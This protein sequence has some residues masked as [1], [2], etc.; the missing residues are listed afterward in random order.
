MSSRNRRATVVSPQEAPKTGR[1]TARIVEPIAG[2]ALYQERARLAFPLLVRQAEA[3]Q[4]II[5]SD[6]S[7]ELGMPNPRNLNYVLGSIG[8]TIEN[9]SKI[10]KETIPPIQS[11][12][13]NK[14]TGLPGEGVSWFLRDWGDF[15]NLPRR[16]QKELVA[17]AHAMVFAY[18][19]WHA[20][21]RKF[22]LEPVN[23][24]FSSFVQE[25]SGPRTGF[26]GGEGERHRALKR[27]VARNPACIGLAKSTPP[28]RNERPL[29]SGDCVDVSFESTEQWI[30]AEVKTTLSDVADITR[31]L[32]QCVKYRAVMEAVQAAEGRPRAAR[33]ILVLEGKLPPALISLRNVL[34]VEVQEGVSGS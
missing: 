25:A 12:V 26:G 5:Y 15:G 18:P 30:A 17:G 23:T 24:N 9:L 16:Q 1:A 6:L 33:A 11:L 29:P 21:L 20:V 3:G 8:Q 7:E 22:S 2:D 10:W 27:F 14:N 34:G 31:G 4:P 19:R 28:G 13:V 32:F